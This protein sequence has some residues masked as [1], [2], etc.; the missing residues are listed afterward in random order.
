MQPPQFC[1][2]QHRTIITHSCTQ[3]ITSSIRLQTRSGSWRRTAWCLLVPAV[4]ADCIGDPRERLRAST[5]VLL[6]NSVVSQLTHLRLLAVCLPIADGLSC[7]T[8]ARLSFLY[9]DAIL[10]AGFCFQDSV[11]VLPESIFTGLST[12]PFCP[13]QHPLPWE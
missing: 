3:Q 13:C 6:Q 12:W 2:N 8:P 5:F 10:S 7:M 9:D 4:V 1:N 11:S